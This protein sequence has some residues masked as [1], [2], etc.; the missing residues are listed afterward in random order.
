MY[1]CMIDGSDAEART[2]SILYDTIRYDTRLDC[3]RLTLFLYL[4]HTPIPISN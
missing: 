4:C 1:V 3:T 2:P